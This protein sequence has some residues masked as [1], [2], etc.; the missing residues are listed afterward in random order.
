MGLD[1]LY[2][3]EG[4]KIIYV[5]GIS[6]K[7]VIERWLGLCLPEGVEYQV[8]AL[9]GNDNISQKFVKPLIKAFGSSVLVLLD[10][11]GSN[12][13]ERYSSNVLRLVK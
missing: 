2:L 4:G 12:A 13:T 9:G 3:G 7:V 10:S 11:D 8:V 6:D 1:P 5:E